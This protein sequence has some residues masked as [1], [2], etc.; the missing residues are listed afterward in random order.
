MMILGS[1]IFFTGKLSWVACQEL[2]A[3]FHFKLAVISRR[4]SSNNCL[5][6]KSN[7]T[8]CT[9]VKLT[10]S[11]NHFNLVHPDHLNPFL[12][13]QRMLYQHRLV[14]EE[15][16]I[17]VHDLLIKK[18]KATKNVYPGFASFKDIKSEIYDDSNRYML[19]I[20]YLQFVSILTFLINFKSKYI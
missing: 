9:P 15:K 17:R 11:V 1:I 3:L 16:R 10:A 6:N 12:P 20:Y 14:I 5:I 8:Q 4:I 19:C 13:L 2:L 18:Q 7:R